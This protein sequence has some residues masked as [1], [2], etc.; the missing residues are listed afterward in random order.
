MVSAFTD[1]LSP[2]IQITIQ[3]QSLSQVYIWNI[4]SEI[5]NTN[6]N[7]LILNENYL[8]RL[9]LRKIICVYIY[10]ERE[11]EYIGI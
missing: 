7:F 5:W 11:K 8:Y 9:L 4:V 6:Q 10:R 1:I 3:I 2:Y